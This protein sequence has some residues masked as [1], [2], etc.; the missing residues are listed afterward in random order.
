MKL[1]FA[2]C[3]I[4]CCSNK[5][6]MLDAKVPQDEIGKLYDG[7]AWFYD[8]WAYLTE[9]KARKELWNSQRFRMVNLS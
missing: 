7:K 8:F 9:S 6:H 1:S 2:C 4:E 5:S 3:G